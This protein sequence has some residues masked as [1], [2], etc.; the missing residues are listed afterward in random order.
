VGEPNADQA[1]GAARIRLAAL[2]DEETRFHDA[3][4]ASALGVR[5]GDRV[6]DLG[7]GTGWS[8]RLAARAAGPTGKVLGVDLSADSLEHARRL[9]RA[10]GLR[11][12]QYRRADA[13]TLVLPE[14]EFDVAI[15]SFGSMFFADPVSAFTGVATALRAAGRLVLIVWQGRAA[16]EWSGAV[17]A[18]I[19]G[20]R[21]LPEPDDRQSAF[22]LGD[23]AVTTAVLHE[24]GFSSVR[25][26]GVEAPV[27]Y[28]ADVREAYEFVTALRDTRSLLAEL[29]D[30]EAARA[31]LRGLLHDHLTPE[32]VLFDGATWVITAA[33][34]PPA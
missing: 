20:G 9:T 23:P 31:R 19:G 25:F 4:F 13:Q 24:A 8:T 30:P 32:G 2:F 7:C 11:T 21:P 33:R 28:G 5:S 26:E 17:R 1:A 29:D 22:S 34:V 10:E 15:S 6:L 12:I 18:A 14:N 16:N 3:A 27:R